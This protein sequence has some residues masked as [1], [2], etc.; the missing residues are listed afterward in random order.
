MANIKTLIREVIRLEAENAQLVV[1]VS[2]LLEAM[3]ELLQR[4]KVLEQASV[5]EAF[6]REE[7][8]RPGEVLR[9]TATSSSRDSK[10]T[11]HTYRWQ[12]V[13]GVAP[14]VQVEDGDTSRDEQED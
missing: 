8:V 14:R 3:N 5:S 7:V 1:K 12:T 6:T 4:V 13:S 11:W 10:Y 2:S 9:M